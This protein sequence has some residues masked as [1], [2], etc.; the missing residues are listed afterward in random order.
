VGEI[1]IDYHKNKN[2]DL[3]R[4]K[5]V[6]ESQLDLAIELNRSVVIHC[7]RAH[8]D[9]LK[10]LERKFKKKKKP[11]VSEED[12]LIAVQHVNE[13]DG[14]ISNEQ[15]DINDLTKKELKKYK[16]MKRKIIK[17]NENLKSEKLGV[18]TSSYVKYLVFVK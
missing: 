5:E 18:N 4:Q 7:V 17:Y 1:G 14:K 12:Y 8:G 13:I 15:K 6:F 3:N 10:I 2:T 11:M 9:L 16:K